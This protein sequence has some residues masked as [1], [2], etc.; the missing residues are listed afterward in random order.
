MS[1]GRG[2]CLLALVGTGVATV[3]FLLLALRRG[4]CYQVCPLS[5]VLPAEDVSLAVEEDS[6]EQDLWVNGRG[7]RG[8]CLVW[9]C[10]W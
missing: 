6:L 9:R 10:V 8:F 7:S 4:G 3:C 5:S 1:C 2:V